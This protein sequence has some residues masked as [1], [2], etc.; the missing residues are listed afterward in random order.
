MGSDTVFIKLK[1]EN[2]TLCFDLLNITSDY[3]RHWLKLVSKTVDM[4][5]EYC[6]NTDSYL[7]DVYFI[8]RKYNK[9]N[10]LDF[11]YISVFTEVGSFDVSRPS[12][13]YTYGKPSFNSSNY[14]NCDA[15]YKQL[16]TLN[17]INCEA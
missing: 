17:F 12:N 16:N 11:N 14:E 6:K 15:I 8:H 4:I 3:R 1:E 13:G 7:G 2:F 5:N 9:Y 10:P